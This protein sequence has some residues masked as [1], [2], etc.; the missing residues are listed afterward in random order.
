MSDPII[1]VQHYSRWDIKEVTQKKILTFPII[2]PQSLSY[3]YY[4]PSKFVNNGESIKPSNVPKP[5]TKVSRVI[6]T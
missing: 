5:K 2:L 3:K 4:F 6:G 1:L